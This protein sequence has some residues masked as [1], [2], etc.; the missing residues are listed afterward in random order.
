MKGNGSDRSTSPDSPECLWEYRPGATLEA[1]VVR[2]GTIDMQNCS[3]HARFMIR[4]PQVRKISR[5]RYEP[6]LS[7]KRWPQA[8]TPAESPDNVQGQSSRRTPRGSGVVG[9]A[10][11]HSISCDNRGAEVESSAPQSAEPQRCA[12]V[13]FTAEISPEFIHSHDIPVHR[14]LSPASKFSAKV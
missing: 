10:Y 5:A 7:A 8:T 3:S 13:A 4:P 9:G 6:T 2:L 1:I 14:R 12:A 11:E